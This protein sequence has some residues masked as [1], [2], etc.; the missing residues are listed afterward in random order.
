MAGGKKLLLPPRSVSAAGARVTG[1]RAGIVEDQA[2]APIASE[3]A[4]VPVVSGLGAAVAPACRPGNRPEVPQGWATFNPEVSLAVHPV[5]APVNRSQPH[6]RHYVV[7]VQL[8]AIDEH[9]G[10]AGRLVSPKGATDLKAR[11]RESHGRPPLTPQ[12]PELWSYQ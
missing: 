10:V 9:P 2:A 3:H 7:L 5:P 4:P 6:Q 11:Q 8:P 12:A 1:P